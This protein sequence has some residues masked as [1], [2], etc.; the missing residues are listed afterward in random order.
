MTGKHFI[1]SVDRD[2]STQPILYFNGSA[3]TMAGGTIDL[4]GESIRQIAKLDLNL[5]EEDSFFQD[6]VIWKTALN[7]TDA[8]ALY[9]SG[10]WN[11]PRN[12]NSASAI[13][14]WYRMG[15]ELY[16]RRLGYFSGSTLAGITTLSFQGS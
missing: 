16:L 4:S 5:P 2:I 12:H 13:V 14:D 7:S 11:D 3:A 9:N 10:H 8:T 6:L 1:I 15:N